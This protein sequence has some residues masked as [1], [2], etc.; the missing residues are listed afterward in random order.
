MKI[1]K[2]LSL[3]LL[4]MGSQIYSS[5]NEKIIEGTDWNKL[6]ALDRTNE[7]SYAKAGKLMVTAESSVVTGIIGGNISGNTSFGIALAPVIIVGVT[8]GLTG[9]KRNELMDSTMT[10]VVIGSNYI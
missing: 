6:V 10:N 3:G 7:S 1:I 8:M 4:L 9:M 5:D 2:M